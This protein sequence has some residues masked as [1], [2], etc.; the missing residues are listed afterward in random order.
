MGNASRFL[1]Q[2]LIAWA[3]RKG[4]KQFTAVQERA[5][6]AIA[7]GQADLLIGGRTSSGKTEAVF[8]P[9]VSMAAGRRGG[10]SVLAISPT[11]ALINDQ[12]RRLL[13][14]AQCVGVKVHAW[15]GETSEQKK[16]RV[17]AQPS[18]IF[19]TTPESL[20]G[21]FLRQPRLVKRLFA[22]LDA[23]VIDEQHH[24]LSGPRGHQLASLLAR[25]DRYA[26]KPIRKIGISATLGD[27]EYAR[28][29]LSTA[30]PSSVRL[31]DDQGESAKLYS[32]IRGYRAPTAKSVPTGRRRL[33]VLQRATLAPI[34]AVLLETHKLG[35]HLVFAGSKQHV[36]MLCEFLKEQAA[37]QSLPDRFR[38][39]H[40]AMGQKDRERTE[41]DLRSGKPLTVITTSTLELGVD[42]GT[43]DAIDQIGAPHSITAFRQRIGRSGRRDDPAIVT[44][45]VTEEPM[46]AAFSLLDRLRLNNAR[47]IAALNL[48][49]NKFVEPVEADGTM[50]TVVL[51]QTLSFIRENGGANFPELARLVRSVTPFERLSERSY[52]RLLAELCEPGLALL[53]EAPNGKFRLAPMGEK[54]LESNEIYAAFKAFHAWDVWARGE[55]KGTLLRAMPVEPG[56]VFQLGGQAWEAV[57]VHHSRNRIKVEPAP[58]GRAPYF[59]VSGE[60]DVDPALAREMQRV[61]LEDGPEPS[62]CDEMSARFLLEGRAAFRD[63]GLKDRIVVEDP[64][65]E[66]CHLFTWRGSRFNALLATLL[67]YKRFACDANEVAVS[68]SHW[69]AGDIIEALSADLPSVEELSKFIECLNVG[70]FDKWIPEELLREDWAKRNAALA[71]QVRQFCVSLQSQ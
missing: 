37:A 19:I 28:R 30:A 24:F 64:G 6:G 62:D 61:L 3:R 21:R 12:H 50:L 25:L 9:L 55:H 54:L 56:D 17:V 46:E 71:D 68:V 59:G 52:E 33:Q 35:T 44:I 23:I 34:S 20:E 7:G 1:D 4:W 49:A 5:I 31:I 29:W 32:L 70:K 27:A 42:I 18:G 60:D 36:E 13:G 11:K 14:M 63:A 39:H 66:V 41:E 16:R 58:S 57:A 45:H 38:A 47:A 51:Q 26:P 48:L 2:R 67:R 8:L 69:S 15:H 65:Q 43:V 10:I 53:C 40:G 22:G